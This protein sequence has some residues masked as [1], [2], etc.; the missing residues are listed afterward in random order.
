MP[1]ESDKIESMK[2]LAEL[3]SINDAGGILE[4]IRAMVALVERDG[5]L[6]SW[7]RA[8]ASHK[9]KYPLAGNLQDCLAK[10]EKAKIHGRLN[11]NQQDRFVV[12][13]GLDEDA[14]TIFCDCVLI[15]L[16]DGRALFVAERFDADSSLQEII[17]HLNRRL[18]MFQVESESAKK[19][20]RN[21]Q[22]EVEAIL[23]QAKELS[24]VDVLTF[25]PN[26]RMIVRELQDEVLRAER[27]NTPFS[28]SVA[29]VDFFK[30]V[31]DSY[32]HLVGDEVLR[33]VGYQ[34]RD[35]IRHPDLA[36]RYGGE[37]FLILLPNTASAEAA[38]QAARLC[39]YVRET[40]VHVNNHVL[41]V[42][43][44]IGVAQFQ[45][46]L[47]TWDTLLNRADNAMYEAK[48]NGRDCLFV[49]D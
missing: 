45:P 16:A 1:S 18:K 4:H 49:A 48:K 2:Q 3:I 13:I 23:T 25:L 31:N 41:S 43:I 6:V 14:K 34:L 33:H 47:D 10:K 32:G 12:E 9:E 42:T 38:E 37:E 17:Q 20:A 44:S 5:T 46:G 39:K 8:F 40:K 28:I 15:P 27:Y 24:N 7:N 22:T 29:D 36:G 26:R 35:H 11:V 19:I 30:K 21:K